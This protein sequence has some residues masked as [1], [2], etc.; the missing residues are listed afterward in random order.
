[1]YQGE[2]VTCPPELSE[3]ELII[4]LCDRW[5]KTPAEIRELDAD[6]LRLLNI[7]GFAAEHKNKKEE[8]NDEPE[9]SDY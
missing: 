6:D 5:H 1:V 2:I 7:Y 3:A 9:Q 8:A 4:G